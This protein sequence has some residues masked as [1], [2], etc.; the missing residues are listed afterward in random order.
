M[1]IDRHARHGFDI[2]VGKMC[3]FVARCVL[4]WRDDHAVIHCCDNVLMRVVRSNKHHGIEYTRHLGKAQN[5]RRTKAVAANTVLGAIS[6][7]VLA[8]RTLPSALWRV[9]TVSSSLRRAGGLL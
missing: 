7:P 8:V 4:D 9:F 6:N 2:K 5:Y 3:H 1:P